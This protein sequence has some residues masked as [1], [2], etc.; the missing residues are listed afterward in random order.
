VLVVPVKHASRGKSRLAGVLSDDDRAA[1]ARA[2]ALDTV[3]AALAAAGVDQVIVVSADEVVT[4]ALHRVDRVWLLPE[5]AV[6]AG[7]DR[8]NTAVDVGIVEARR[9]WPAAGVA[10]LL[11][12]LPLLVPVELE[13]ALHTAA[14]HERSL[15][16]DWQG[17]GTTLLAARPG[18]ELTPAFGAR[19]AAAHEAA[20]HLRIDLVVGSGLRRDVDLPGDLAR[21]RGAVLGART[22]AAM[23]AA[24]LHS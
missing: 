19:S 23:E 16:V 14:Q 17:T 10:V 9:R 18:V 22:G 12:D 6:V 7:R 21:L 1:L 11:A 4:T 3:E 13:V 24:H 5:P 2:M 20:G 8:L 15:V